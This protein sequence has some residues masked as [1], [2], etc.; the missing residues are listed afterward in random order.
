M[1]TEIHQLI[2][3]ELL[4][5]ARLCFQV[6]ARHFLC[7]NYAGCL[8]AVVVREGNT[9][10]GVDGCEYYLNPGSPFS[11]KLRQYSPTIDVGAAVYRDDSGQK[12]SVRFIC[13]QVGM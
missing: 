4:H 12:F 1:K 13:L 6:Q 9:V 3:H 5:G 10:L 7:Y 11:A 8:C 2:R